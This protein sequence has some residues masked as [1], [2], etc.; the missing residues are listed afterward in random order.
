MS[1]LITLLNDSNLY[2]L[3]FDFI[4][5]IAYFYMVY[6]IAFLKL[7]KTLIVI[8]RSAINFATFSITSFVNSA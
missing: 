8:I 5:D 3:L 4:M 7:S 1:L 2:I 6:E